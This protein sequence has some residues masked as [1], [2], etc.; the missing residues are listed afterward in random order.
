MLVNKIRANTLYIFLS[1]F[2]FSSFCEAEI[3]PFDGEYKVTY[4]VF[5]ADGQRNLSIDRNG[6][7]HVSSHISLFFLTV[8][9]T[10]SFRVV[11][12]AV[13]SIDYRYKNPLS[14]DSSYA[15]KFDWANGRAV[16]KNGALEIPDKSYDMLGYQIQLQQDVCNDKLDFEALDFNL[17]VKSRVKK[18][19]VEMIGIDR[20]ST[21]IGVFDA[22]HLRQF[23]P[24]KQGGDV[25]D[26][27]FAEGYGC[28]LL[29]IDQMDD[30]KLLK[31][32]LQ[33]ASVDG[34]AVIGV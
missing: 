23:R 16:G 19:R 14:R 4:G 26:I 24:E 17:V 15:V 5:D 30:G 8:E 18:Y 29:R 6:V 25:T 12:G 20:L 13:R 34:I 33:K 7:W 3:R 1:V 32:E 27:W 28:L 31:L 21:D 9:E 10:A 22:Y 2:F 11:G